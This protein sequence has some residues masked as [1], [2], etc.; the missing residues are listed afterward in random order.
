MELRGLKE[1]KGL[2]ALEVPKVLREQ[3]VQQVLLVHRG[4]EVRK[5]L[6]EL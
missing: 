4:Q 3:P 2:K 5:E 6:K 1:L